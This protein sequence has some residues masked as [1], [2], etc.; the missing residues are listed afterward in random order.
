MARGMDKNI[1]YLGFFRKTSIWFDNE[2]FK[3]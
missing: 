3:I 1:K 2:G